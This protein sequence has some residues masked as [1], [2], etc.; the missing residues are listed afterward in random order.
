MPWTS[1]SFGE[2]QGKTLPQIIFKDPDWF[3]YLYNRGAFDNKSAE[4]KE[5]AD[6]VY[7]KAKNISV[8]QIYEEERSIV[9]YICHPSTGKIGTLR[10]V[11]ESRPPHEG[12][13][14]IFRRDK[15]DLEIP[16]EIAGGK[17]KQGNKNMIKAL[18]HYLLGNERIHLTKKRCEEFFENN[19]NFDI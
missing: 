16:R 6:Q 1:I 13:S 5:E 18:K 2:H 9:E 12:S 8:P 11:P 4:E 17:D 15:I 10:I 19:D 7:R 14:P 3:F